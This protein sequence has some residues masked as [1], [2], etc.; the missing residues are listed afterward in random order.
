MNGESRAKDW[1]V[2]SWFLQ[3]PLDLEGSP[4]DAVSFILMKLDLPQNTVR[5]PDSRDFFQLPTAARTVGFAEVTPD[6][7]PGIGRNNLN[8]GDA[9]DKLKFHWL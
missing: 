1:L 6:A 3:V 7:D 5:Q 2:V 9:P 8:L 4:A